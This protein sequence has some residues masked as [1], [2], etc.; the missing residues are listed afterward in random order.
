MK[1]LKNENVLF[2]ETM[3]KNIDSEEKANSY[4]RYYSQNVGR[5]RHQ[6]ES[7]GWDVNDINKIIDLLWVRI[8]KACIKFKVPFTDVARENAKRLAKKRK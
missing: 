5:F 6:L 3:Y 4:L 7:L 8:L 2:D 1:S